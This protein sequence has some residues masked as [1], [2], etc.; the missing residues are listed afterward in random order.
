MYIGEG[1][2]K[3]RLVTKKWSPIAHVFSP[4]RIAECFG[5]VHKNVQALCLTL[6]A[7]LK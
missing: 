5:S 6:L 2:A 4:M 1:D 7:L 3:V